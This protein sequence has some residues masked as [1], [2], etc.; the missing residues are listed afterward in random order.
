MIAPGSSYGERREPP[1]GAI[2]VFDDGE[3]S[4]VISM[5]RA[6]GEEPPCLI[7]RGGDLY[8][9]LGGA[10]TKVRRVGAG[11]L[12]TMPVDLGIIRFDGQERV[13]L[14]HAIL[15][16][17]AWRGR[18]EVVMNAQWCGDLDLG[19]KS[20]PGDGLLDVTVGSLTPR[21]RIAARSRARS[22]THLP[23]PALTLRRVATHELDSGHRT[24]LYLDGRRVA[25]CRRASVHIE[26]GAVTV[27]I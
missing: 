2:E 20:H 12:V 11:T 10:G 9:T 8:R 14:A 7:L 21:Q 22:G 17:P 18:F 19:P 3:A 1:S 13:F 4:S 26:P 16:T 5:W 23:H 27:F 24:S 15:R 6:R 25:S